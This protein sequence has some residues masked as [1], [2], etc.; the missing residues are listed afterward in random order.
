MK[1]IKCVVS[2]INSNGESDFHPVIIEC[3]QD[4]VDDGAHCQKAKEHAEDAGYE[5]FLVYDEHDSAWIFDNHF[6][7]DNP[8]QVEC[9]TIPVHTTFQF[10]VMEQKSIPFA[11]HDTYMEAWE[12][13]YQW[14]KTKM[15]AGTLSFQVL[16]TAVW[17]TIRTGELETP[18]MFNDARDKAIDEHGWKVPWKDPQ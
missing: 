7:W 4:F 8:K 2:C 12:D 1:K 5:A 10:E 6:L 16:E 11:K 15:K 13:M 3:T 14:V 18:L 17:I 9:V